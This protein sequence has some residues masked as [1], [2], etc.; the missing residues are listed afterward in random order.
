MNIVWFLVGY[1]VGVIASYISYW[2]FRER[3]PIYITGEQKVEFADNTIK[4]IPKVKELLYSV[5]GANNGSVIEPDN[6]DLYDRAETLKD[7]LGEE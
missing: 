7:L 2:L 5:T 1:V 4:T 3:H 6:S